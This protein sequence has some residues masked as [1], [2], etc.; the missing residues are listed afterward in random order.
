MI[1]LFSTFLLEIGD[2][3]ADTTLQKYD[4]ITPCFIGFT[5]PPFKPAADIYSL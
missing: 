1:C 5:I 2:A 4:V 3:A